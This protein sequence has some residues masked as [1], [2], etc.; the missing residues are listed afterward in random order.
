MSET[1][2]TKSL[3]PP[4]RERCQCEIT[5]TPSPFTMGGDLRPKTERCS[6]KASV[7]ITEKVPGDD[8][9]IGAMSLCAHCFG[10]F[11]KRVGLGGVHVEVLT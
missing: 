8:G 1:K 5:T 10:V 6:G 4:D 9:Q 11:Q 2:D 7:V 3:T